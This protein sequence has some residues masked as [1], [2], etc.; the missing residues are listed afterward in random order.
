M[1][2]IAGVLLLISAGVNFMTMS[3]MSNEKDLATKAAQNAKDSKD[4][5]TEASTNKDET[6][7]Q[8]K[9]KTSQAEQMAADLADAKAKTAEA[10]KKLEAS[11]AKHDEIKKNKDAMDKQFNEL[12]GLQAIVDDMKATQAKKTENDV[13]IQQKEAQMTLALQRK[14]QL[15]LSLTGLKKKDMMQKTGL[16][17]D[18]FR[19][20]ISNIDPNWGFIMINKGNSSGVVK[21]AK[22]DVKRG[23]D[24]IATLVV[25]NVQPSAAICDVVPGTL[26]EGQSLQPGD[27][28]RV[29]SASS[30]RNAVIPDST[31]AAVTPEVG[32]GTPATGSPAA[33][34]ATAADPFAPSA[35]APAPAPDPFAP[36][37]APAQ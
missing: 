34:P 1:S 4:H 19:G 16:M 10:N 21:N 13:A 8:L 20:S 36:A 18:G 17:N 33:A 23:S 5:A 9:S 22:L 24:T 28:L 7:G 15:E 6:K 3:Q 37:P 35:A 31:P 12:G 29:N 25:T 32:G 30:E 2:I 11:T 14:Q 26:A 27:T